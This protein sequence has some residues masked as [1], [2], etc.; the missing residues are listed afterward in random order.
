MEMNTREQVV[1]ATRE[2]INQMR[3]K[4]RESDE[5]EARATGETNAYSCAV[6]VFHS[7]KKAWTGLLY[8]KP[9]VMFGGT[10]PDFVTGISR[11][12]M[13]GTDDMR[14]AG[15][16]VLRRTRKY[17]KELRD[18]ADGLEA[19]VHNDNI[20]SMKWLKWIGFNPGGYE[21]DSPLFYNVWM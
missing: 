3:G 21:E 14:K 4:F 13:F 18:N 2:H 11:P 9:I 5:R 8:G 16:S 12:W 7:S 17:M 10:D 6:Q 20:T 1:P 15:L 19:R